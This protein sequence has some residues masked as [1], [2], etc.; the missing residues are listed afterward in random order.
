VYVHRSSGH[1]YA[2]VQLAASALDGPAC[3]I[4]GEQRW[5]RQ[6]A[7]YARARPATSH[8]IP[9]T[10]SEFTSPRHNNDHDMM[11]S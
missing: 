1:A 11:Q 5:E 10:S 9:V 4:E 6:E 2:N 7:S 3:P 8:L